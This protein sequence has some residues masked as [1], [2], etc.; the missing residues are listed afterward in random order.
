[1]RKGLNRHGGGLSAP[2]LTDKDLE[3]VKLAAELGVD[4]LAVSFARDAPDIRR[5][6]S[7]LRKYRGTAHVIAKIERHEAIENLQHSLGVGDAVMVARGDLGVEMGYAE[8]TGLQK[9]IIQNALLRNR[10]VI[11]ATQMMESMIQSPVPTR[12]EV[13]DV[14]NAVLD[15][16]DAVM[17]SAETAVG[18]HPVE[19]VRR[20]TR[21]A[22]AAQ[23]TMFS[24]APATGAPRRAAREDFT[25]EIAR[26]A[27]HASREIDAR[28]IGVF[29][30]TGRTARLLS[31]ERTRCPVVAFSP[32]EAAV[33]RL[34][35]YWGVAPRR[36]PEMGTVT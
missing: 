29:T 33:R 4:F 28:A 8:L 35:L 1:N 25:P 2:A 27:G 30:R 13:S 10:V 22:D 19:V 12:A 11:T 24:Y 18:K 6:Q 32:D 26:L 23:E 3:D 17:L 20:I 5:A 15:G 21:I 14:A 36:I 9:T 16:T 31:S 7:E 34:A